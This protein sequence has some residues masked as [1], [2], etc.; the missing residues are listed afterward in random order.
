MPDKL[1]W[2]WRALP[3]SE[4]EPIAQ[5]GCRIVVGD[6]TDPV[7]WSAGYPVIRAGLDHSHHSASGR[8]R[9]AGQWSEHARGGD[10]HGLWTASDGGA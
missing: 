9:R 7:G 1:S 10:E 4:L 2:H 8:A 3:L 5:D 6:G